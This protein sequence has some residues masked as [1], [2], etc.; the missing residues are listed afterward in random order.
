MYKKRYRFY[1]FITNGLLVE[2]RLYKLLFAI[3]L[4][5]LNNII[6]INF[7]RIISMFRISTHTMQKVPNLGFLNKFYNVIYINI[8]SCHSYICILEFCFILYF[9]PFILY[10][11]PFSF[12]ILISLH[13]VYYICIYNSLWKNSV[14]VRNYFYFLISEI[15]IRI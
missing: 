1:T 11:F 5:Y 4:I 2:I 3:L 6:Q 7:T 9:I 13:F 15:R 8:I 12:F 14:V 10:F